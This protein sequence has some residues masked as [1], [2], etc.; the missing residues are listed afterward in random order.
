VGYPRTFPRSKHVILRS[1][2]RAFGAC[3]ANQEMHIATQHNICAANQ[4]RENQTMAPR[5]PAFRRVS[6]LG[7]PRLIVEYLLKNCLPW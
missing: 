3:A 5:L 1:Y 7:R 4:E 2:E 6:L